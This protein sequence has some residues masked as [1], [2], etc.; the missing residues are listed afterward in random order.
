MKTLIHFLIQHGYVVLFASVLAEQVG[1]PLPAVPFLLAMGA[2]AGLGQFSLVI[3]FL[4]SVLACVIGDAIWYALG[5][6][7]GNSVLKL[8]CRISLEPDSCVNQTRDAFGRQGSRALLIAKFVPGL[9][10]MAPPMAGLTRMPFG[11]FVLADTAGSMFWAASFLTLG[12]L[13]HDQVEVIAEAVGRFGSAAGFFAVGLL[14]AW[15][16]FK[17]VQRRR[18]VHS[19]RTARISPQSV[20]EQ[21][22]KGQPLTILD[23][24]HDT[25]EGDPIVP[26]AIRMLLEDLD[27]RY[28]ELPRDRDIILYCT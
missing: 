9:S 3:A 22:E 1:V 23:M 2:L 20:Y 6:A 24:R 28:K 13:F 8:L 4:L 19:L 16:A 26:G 10:T 14:G 5:R 25:G 12:Y 7:R 17:Y 18:F 21:M 11:R 27:A 15:I